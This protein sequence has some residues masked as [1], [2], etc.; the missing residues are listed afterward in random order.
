MEAGY[1]RVVSKC[2]NINIPDSNYYSDYSL[3]DVNGFRVK[4]LGLKV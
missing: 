4:G 2:Q 1:I 3:R